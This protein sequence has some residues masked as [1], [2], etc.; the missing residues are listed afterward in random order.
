MGGPWEGSRRTW[1]PGPC[2]G[3]CGR[4]ALTLVQ[5]VSH[6]SFPGTE[7]PVGGKWGQWAWGT[8]AFHLGH[9]RRRLAEVARGCM[10]WAR[11]GQGW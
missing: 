2:G 4:G 9:E 8:P 5:D 7:N 3:L 6:R 1:A 10:C 11:E